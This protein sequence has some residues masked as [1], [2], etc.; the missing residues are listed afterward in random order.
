MKRKPPDKTPPS[1]ADRVKAAKEAFITSASSFVT[2]V[3][4]I[5]GVAIGTGLPGEATKRLREIYIAES[6]KTSI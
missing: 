6:R 1:P 2:P 4:E 5:D 3:V